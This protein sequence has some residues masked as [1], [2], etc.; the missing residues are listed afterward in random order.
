MKVYCHLCGATLRNG[1]QYQQLDTS[2]HQGTIYVCRDERRC[3]LRAALDPLPGK[4]QPDPARIGI[5]NDA[6]DTPPNTEQDLRPK[7]VVPS[8]PPR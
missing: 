3:V 6:H 5:L 2:P 7:C 8:T 4:A 1:D